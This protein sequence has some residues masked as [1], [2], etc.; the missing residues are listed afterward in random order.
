M[1]MDDFVARSKKLASAFDAWRPVPRVLVGMYGYLL[2]QIIMWFMGLPDPTNAQAG[3]VS[4]VV[5]AAAG[6]FGFYVNS[7]KTDKKE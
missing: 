5:G 7:G 2:Y 3:F 1:T 6:F 4:A